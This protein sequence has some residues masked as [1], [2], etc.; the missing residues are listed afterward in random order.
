[1][2]ESELSSTDEAFYSFTFTKQNSPKKSIEHARYDHAVRIASCILPDSETVISQVEAQLSDFGEDT[3]A[4]HVS[5]AKG[6]VSHIDRYELEEVE[7]NKASEESGFQVMSDCGWFCQ[8]VWYTVTTSGGE[9]ISVVI[10]CDP[11]SWLYTCEPMEGGGSG[12]D[13]PIGEEPECEDP[14]MPCYD[15]PGGPTP[16]DECEWALTPPPGICAQ[17]EVCDTSDPIID[18]YNVQLAMFEVWKDSYGPN[19]DPLDDNDR[20]ERMFMVTATS[21]GYEIEEFEP[22]PDTSPCHFDGGSISIP[23]NIVALFHT[24]PF[25]DGDSVNATSCPPVY[26][27]DFV[28]QA[29]RNLVEEIANNLALPAIPMYVMDKDKIRVLDPSD[30]SQYSQTIDRCGF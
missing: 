9:V 15:G 3:W 27:G 8:T 24:H 14:T 1:M 22:G 30:T 26:N 23:S 13:Y 29:D 2:E 6:V 18:D 10:E 17:P 20:R 11:Q 4:G 7:E 25:G 28:S 12:L 5:G 19:H 21:S 16:V